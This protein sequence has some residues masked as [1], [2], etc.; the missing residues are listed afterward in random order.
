MKTKKDSFEVHFPSKPCKRDSTDGTCR[1][2]VPTKSN[3]VMVSFYE[4]Y[5]RATFIKYQCNLRLFHSLP[6]PV[7]LHSHI[8]SYSLLCYVY[9]FGTHCIT[10]HA[11]T[12]STYRCWSL[13]LL[14]SLFAWFCWV[15]RVDLRKCHLSKLLQLEHELV[16]PMITW[17]TWSVENECA[18]W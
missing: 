12:Y 1:I 9:L 18:R 11:V 6:C 7:Y 3:C 17:I 4:R 10:Y 15:N 5:H 16:T 2:Q 8:F 13:C 14:C